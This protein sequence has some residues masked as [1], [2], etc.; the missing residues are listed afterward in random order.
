M[1][2]VLISL[3]LTFL[4]CHL[5]AQITF[6][7]PGA[8]WNYSFYDGYFD[9]SIFNETVSYANDSLVDNDSV[10]VLR[11]NWFFK[12]FSPVGGNGKTFLKQKGDTV[13][14]RNSWTN[15]QWQILYNF[16][17]LPGQS[18]TNVFPGIAHYTTT[19]NSVAVVNIGG[20]SL[21]QLQVSYSNYL[22]VPIMSATSVP[23]Q[24]VITE[25]FGS[26]GFIFN[27]FC[28]LNMH[29]PDLDKFLCYTDN[30]MGVQAFTD[31]PCNYSNLTDLNEM[32][33]TLH[34]KIYP[35]PFQDHLNIEGENGLKIRLTDLSGRLLLDDKVGSA[36]RIHAEALVPG[37]Y[38]LHIFKNNELILKTKIIKE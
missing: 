3:V 26:D 13:F 4:L 14:M 27:Y 20:H 38:F 11:H 22:D 31:K 5:S 9:G 17:A 21:K 36:E 34:L 37:L 8:K 15:D 23:Y 19:V 18:W 32:G 30:K 12:R 1:K 35:N 28:G 25:R 16:A 7:P 10:K 29:G 6:C 33:N 24:G 2:R